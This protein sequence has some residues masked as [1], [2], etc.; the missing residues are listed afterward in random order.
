ME[1]QIVQT[2]PCLS[3]TSMTLNAKALEHVVTSHATVS[4]RAVSQIQRGQFTKNTL[5]TA[6]GLV[7]NY[8]FSL[9]EEK[10]K[11]QFSFSH[12][13][14]PFAPQSHR[15]TVLPNQLTFGSTI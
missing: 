15:T 11:L 8:S 2:P 10:G 7:A 14:V 5:H 4:F 9:S 13:D 12:T 1:A 3:P 6:L